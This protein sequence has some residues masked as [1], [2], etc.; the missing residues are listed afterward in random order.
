MVK[1]SPTKQRGSV[2]RPRSLSG[3]GVGWLCRVQCLVLFLGCL[4]GQEAADDFPQPF[5]HEFDFMQ[6][7][8]KERRG[9]ERGQGK[10]RLEEGR[11]KKGGREGKE[12]GVSPS[13][14]YCYVLYPYRLTF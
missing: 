5:K 10:E 12:E 6:K 9:G 14:K 3:G 7:N 11:E 2:E 13:P 4:H 1:S 8:W